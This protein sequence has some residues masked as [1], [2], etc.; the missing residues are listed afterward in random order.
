VGADTRTT[1]WAVEPNRRAGGR[2]A[3]DLEGGGI[4]G[5]H[6]RATGFNEGDY[7]LVV[8]SLQRQRLDCRR[9][10]LPRRQRGKRGALWSGTPP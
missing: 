4:G 8:A 9:R 1:W 7:G 2:E 10:W 5:K 6:D 3:V